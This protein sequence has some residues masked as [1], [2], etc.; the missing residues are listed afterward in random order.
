MG[1]NGVTSKNLTVLARKCGSLNTSSKSIGFL[2]EP[3]LQSTVAPGRRIKPPA[4]SYE[5]T[6]RWSKPDALGLGH[7]RSGLAQIGPNLLPR[8]EG[9][10]RRSADRLIGNS[11]RTA[12]FAASGR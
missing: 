10:R 3:L 11:S 9:I 7:I 2:H 8:R 12:P 4:T 6:L 5:Q 1:G